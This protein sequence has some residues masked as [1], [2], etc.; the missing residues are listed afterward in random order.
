[1]LDAVQARASVAAGTVNLAASYSFRE[2]HPYNDSNTEFFDDQKRTN[3][4]INW[5]VPGDKWQVSLY[6]KNLENQAN[7]G[8]L[9]SIAGLFTA[10]PMQK[11]RVI[12][13]EINYRY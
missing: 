8:N 11:G 12:G 13:L 5:F 6:G 1:M 2:G 10:G 9:T 3:A 7:W 4:S